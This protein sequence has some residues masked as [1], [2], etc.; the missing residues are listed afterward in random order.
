MGAKLLECPFRGGRTYEQRCGLERIHPRIAQGIDSRTH[1]LHVDAID[2]V[3][4]TDHQVEQRRIG[5]FDDDLVDHSSTAALEDVDPG[6]ITAHCTD[7]TGQGAQRTGAIRHPDSQ[8][9]GHAHARQPRGP[10]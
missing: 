6:D 2:L 7:P 1:L 3:D 4:L 5:E 9:I 10:K 8:D